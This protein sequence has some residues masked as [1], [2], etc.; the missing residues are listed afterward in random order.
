MEPALVTRLYEQQPPG[1]SEMYVNLFDP[2]AALRPRVEL[3]GY[4][5]KPLWDSWQQ[6]QGAR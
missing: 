6:R 4:V 1:Q 2:P 3:R 5:A